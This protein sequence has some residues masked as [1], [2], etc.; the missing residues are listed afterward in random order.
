MDSATLYNNVECQSVLIL[1]Y[2]RLICPLSRTFEY[3]VSSYHLHFIWNWYEI[4]YFSCHLSPQK[5]H[6]MY[7]DAPFRITK[8]MKNSQTESEQTLK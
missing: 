5:R 8:E 3:V 2:I 7:N 1:L 4:V 6:R